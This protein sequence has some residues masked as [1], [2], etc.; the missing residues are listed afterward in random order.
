MERIYLDHAATTPLCEEAFNRMLPYFKGNFGNADSPHE[1]GRRAM[2]AVDA[3]RDSIAALLNAKPSEVYF[4]SG[5]TEAVN[6]AIYG[7]AAAQKSL[8]KNH[9]VLSAIEHHAALA[10][11]EKLKKEGFEITLV[12][13]NKGGMVELN[14]VKAAL[15]DKTGLVAIMTVNN[16]TGAIQ[17]VEALAKISH[18]NGSL[19]FTDAVQAAPHL[20]IDVKKWG[21]DMLSLS[22]HKFGGGK[23]CGALYIKSG[24]R[25]KSLVV[26]GEQERGL[27]GGTTNVP[28]VVGM[29][30]AYEITRRTMGETEKRLA[31]LR[32]LFLQE[33]GGMSA[34]IVHCDGIPSLLNIRFAGVSNVDF[35]YNMD[36]RG[37]LVA[38]G[39]ACASASI[40]PS[41]V[42]L[43]MGVSETEAKESVRFSLG[44][45]TTEAEIRQAATITREV[46]EKLRKKS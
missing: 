35:V 15:T 33:I 36:L 12:K 46:V 23:G 26:G 6:W 3:A 24:V 40:Q 4:T 20:P 9:I 11:A 25:V 39:S 30:A 8:G 43:A 29:A 27:R 7:G 17:P 21:V 34:F 18:D 45:E 5:G 41:H 16:E 2:N 38:A 42:L 31:E 28:A 14:A 10:M 22:A 1:A 32:Q 44:K 37:V 19:F 13:P